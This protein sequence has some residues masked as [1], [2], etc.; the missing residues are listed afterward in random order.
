MNRQN[1]EVLHSK[2][3]EYVTDKTTNTLIHSLLEKHFYS[4]FPDRAA[5]FIDKQ[6]TDKDKLCIL[7]NSS[8]D[9]I[10]YRA[11]VDDVSVH[12][13]KNL[14]KKI[15]A[16][17]Q[18]TDW[19]TEYSFQRSKEKDLKDLLSELLLSCV[20]SD[21]SS[22]LN[23]TLQWI[24]NISVTKNTKKLILNWHEKVHMIKK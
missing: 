12:R 6:I 20:E 17:I 9:S 15:S 10:F 8:V 24:K 4:F 11:I 5:F 21:R 23:H 14:L 13:D 16:E 1:S 22:S 18:D 2:I 19:K 7:S 3:R